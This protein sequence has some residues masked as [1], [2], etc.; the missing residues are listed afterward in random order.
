MAEPHLLYRVEESAEPRQE[1]RTIAAL[2]ESYWTTHG[3]H[4]LASASLEARLRHIGDYFGALQ[5]AHLNA[6]VVRSYHDM[7][8][9]KGIGPG[10]I[11]VECATLA[12]VLSWARK[13]GWLETTPFVP[14]P[15]APTPRNRFLN[16]DEAQRLLAAATLPHMRL[17]ILVGLHTG[18]RK[19][20]ILELTWERVDLVARRIDFA[21]PG[22]PLTQKKRAVAPINDTLLA[23]LLAAHSVATS[24]YVI[25]YAGASVACLD[26]GF[27]AACERAGLKGVSPHVLRHTAASRMAQG[28]VPLWTAAKIL[29]MSVDMLERIY[30][31]FD[32]EYG[33]DAVKTLEG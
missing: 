1:R 21:T 3:R 29:G 9:G 26:R 4:T 14:K 7:R 25:E 31:H 27:A 30:A 20:A 2:I 19:G 6:A 11:R 5:P 23:G 10:T 8:C 15:R 33:R 13:Q 16:R 12:T 22:R 24:R 28:G 32:P 18:A 17:F